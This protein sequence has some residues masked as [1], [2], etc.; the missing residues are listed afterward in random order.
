MFA[1]L[2][3]ERSETA[4]QKAAVADSLNDSHTLYV[5]WR[6]ARGGER[7]HNARS[8]RSIPRILVAVEHGAMWTLLSE[9]GIVGQH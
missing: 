6:D 1:A 7:Y 9:M 4:E 3:I 5:L 2:A 8:T